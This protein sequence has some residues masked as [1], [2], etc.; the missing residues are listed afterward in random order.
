MVKAD[1][2]ALSLPIHHEQLTFTLNTLAGER[3][4]KVNR[5]FYGFLFNLN[6]RPGSLVRPAT[7]ALRL[8]GMLSR[9]P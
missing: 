5:S 6:G 9:Q 8:I 2:R 3:T 7:T 1:F 4:V